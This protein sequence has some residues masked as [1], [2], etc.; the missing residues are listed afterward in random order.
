M[1]ID[2]VL[3]RLLGIARGGPRIE[4]VE[5][6]DVLVKGSEGTSAIEWFR[7][8]GRVRP[9]DGITE[10]EC[11]MRSWTALNREE[12]RDAGDRNSVGGGLV[13]ATS[14]ECD[15]AGDRASAALPTDLETDGAEPTKTRDAGLL[16][17]SG[18]RTSVAFHGQEDTAA[19]GS[20]SGTEQHPLDMYHAHAE[21]D[22]GPSPTTEPSEPT[23]VPG[24]FVRLGRHR[25]YEGDYNW[26]EE[27]EKYVGWVA[28]VTQDAGRDETGCGIVRV[29]IDGGRFVWRVQSMRALAPTLVR[30]DLRREIIRRLALV[31]EKYGAEDAER[32][33][34]EKLQALGSLEVRMRLR[35][36]YLLIQG[37]EDERERAVGILMAQGVPADSLVAPGDYTPH[38]ALETA[39][40][41]LR[42]ARR[43]Y[44][45]LLL[46][47]RRRDF[48]SREE[49]PL[50][51]YLE[52]IAWAY[53]ELEEEQR[54]KLESETGLAV[55]N[56]WRSLFDEFLAK[57][58]GASPNA[59]ESATWS[60]ARFSALDRIWHLI[61]VAAKM[62]HSNVL[63]ARLDK[64]L[65]E[66]GLLTERAACRFV[67]AH[68]SEEYEQSV[69]EGLRLV[70]TNGL[71]P[72]YVALVLGAVLDLF[73]AQSEALHLHS[74]CDEHLRQAERLVALLPYA[75]AGRTVG[76]YLLLKGDP[77]GAWDVLKA[78][79]GEPRDHELEELRAH[80]WYA[81]FGR[82]LS[83]SL[84]TSVLD[85]I[86]EIIRR[87][88]FVVTIL[89]WALRDGRIAVDAAEANDTSAF[90]QTLGSAQATAVGHVAL[91]R[92][93]RSLGSLH[94]AVGD[95]AHAV[96]Q[97]DQAL[98]NWKL[99]LSAWNAAI[100]ASIERRAPH[101]L[102]TG[103][104]DRLLREEIELDYRS[105][106]RR[107]REVVLDSC[108]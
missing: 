79:T 19:T 67:A 18:T 88:N 94:A 2:E 98:A 77:A 57:G 56:W 62:P 73:E 21:E 55:L 51:A 31:F 33:F 28:V 97:R 38:L 95:A 70:D 69:R 13:A 92:M 78:I 45:L 82:S 63:L 85:A 41:Q 42:M 7:L 24:A 6:E 93:M 76:R 3:R 54:L 11:L 36:T 4:S 106:L 52:A 14:E 9:D 50:A 43:P 10:L 104:K 35:L 89:D 20:G 74:D 60:A 8:V 46:L 47:S 1:N 72:S 32:R 40:A 100:R 108:G 61:A 37:K 16:P 26:N 5:L 81:A 15:T 64:V 39:V 96:N 53:H 48:M 68:G 105:L 30:H 25:T 83:G 87:G 102:L 23:I 66:F 91:V 84:N 80:C 44:K 71:P 86:P 29:D 27:M 107:Y 49:S 99:A 103:R 75:Y 101:R 34:L 58:Y 17:P 12:P 22:A 65:S 90:L 59:M